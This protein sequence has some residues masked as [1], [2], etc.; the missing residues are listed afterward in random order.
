MGMN[1]SILLVSGARMAGKTT[2]CRRLVDAA[3]SR[4]WHVAG[5]LSPARFEGGIKTAIEVEDISTGERRILAQSGAGEALTPGWVFNPAAL[6]WGDEVLGRATPCDLLV[7]DELG[8]LELVASRGWR[9][10]V[11]AINTAQYR[12]ALV[13]VRPELIPAARTRWSRASQVTLPPQQ[14]L[15]PLSLDPLVE[16]IVNASIPPLLP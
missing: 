12:L 10:G 5:V 8:P 6:L 4:G 9:A 2:L 11:A 1:A 14:P 13:V 7:V 3:R 16:E 15:N